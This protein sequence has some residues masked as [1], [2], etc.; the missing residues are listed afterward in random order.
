ME[1]GWLG[2]DG[3]ALKLSGRGEKAAVRGRVVGACIT[4]RKERQPMRAATREPY[5]QRQ[6]N[7][8]H[9]TAGLDLLGS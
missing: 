9:G 7:A 6:P 2:R 4:K 3:D 8:V 1:S 5:D